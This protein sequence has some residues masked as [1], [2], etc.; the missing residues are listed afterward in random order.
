MK[1]SFFKIILIAIIV[2]S[3]VACGD[4]GQIDETN[5][6]KEISSEVETEE[7]EKQIG[8]ETEVVKE[9]EE[10][11]EVE[12]VEEITEERIELDKPFLI[13]DDHE[14][15]FRSMEKIVTSLGDDVLKIIF[16][17]KNNSSQ[18][19]SPSDV[20]HIEG[21][22]NG[23][24]ATNAVASRDE[25]NWVVIVTEVMPGYAIQDCAW[26]LELETDDIIEVFVRPKDSECNKYYSIT[27]NPA[28][29]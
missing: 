16:D 28:E 8:E 15:T 1:S 3:L 13:S 17:W 21:Y 19:Y 22:Q 7:V 24:L 14:V 27:V 23:V 6:E 12:T 18:I 20:V 29:L 10:I 4:T 5:S 9:V 2:L 11:E 26:G 25:V